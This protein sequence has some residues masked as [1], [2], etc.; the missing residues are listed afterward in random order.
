MAILSQNSEPETPN[1]YH[2]MC[3]PDEEKGVEICKFQD[4]DE[5]GNVVRKSEVKVIMDENNKP[6]AKKPNHVGGWTEDEKNYFEQ[7]AL[8]KA[9]E[10]FISD[11]GGLSGHTE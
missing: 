7:R 6:K 4:L 11:R 3:D 8:Q 1:P 5:D 2:E 9:N 10:D